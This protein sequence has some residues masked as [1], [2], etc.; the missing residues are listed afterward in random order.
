M[1]V[2]TPS[3]ALSL[4]NAADWKPLCHTHMATW[5]QWKNKAEALFRRI[6]HMKAE[7]CDS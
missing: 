1:N 5:V 6:L 2:G 4:N 3:L 7:H